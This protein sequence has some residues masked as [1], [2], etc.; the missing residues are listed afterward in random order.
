VTADD[1]AGLRLDYFVASQSLVQGTEGGAKVVDSQAD[2][3]ESHFF[4]RALFAC[5]VGLFS[6]ENSLILNRFEN[7]K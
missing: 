3:P 1:V 5:A 4:N 6:H 7:C 2:T